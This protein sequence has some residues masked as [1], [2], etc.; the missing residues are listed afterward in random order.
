V[1]TAVLLKIQV[2]WVVMLCRWAF[3]CVSFSILE[4]V[5]KTFFRNVG[6]HCAT[7]HNIPV[8][9]NTYFTSFTKTVIIKQMYETNNMI[10]IKDFV[11]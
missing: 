3:L 6:K 7:Q 2:I 1:C 11:S 4:D 10:R 9:P 5:A 8:D